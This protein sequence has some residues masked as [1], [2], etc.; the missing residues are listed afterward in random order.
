MENK[1][2]KNN[3]IPGCDQLTR[4]EE[5]QELSKYLGD[6]KT[7]Q[8]RK[9]KAYM[10]GLD[11]LFVPGH[12]TGLFPEVTLEDHI[13]ALDLG[14]EEEANTVLEKK[15]LE[16]KDRTTPSLGDKI[17]GLS[18]TESSE[19]DER[20]INIPVYNEVTNLP[21]SPVA[22]LVEDKSK[23]EDKLLKIV[24]DNESELET[25]V[26]G[27]G[28]IKPV[29]S[30]EDT[31]IK[32]DTSSATIQDLDSRVVGLNINSKDELGDK[33]IKIHPE[34]DLGLGDKTLPLYD[35]EDP[36]LSN[37][38]LPLY[39]SR[40]G[41]L[42]DKVVKTYDPKEDK[43]ED[44][45]LQINPLEIENLDDRIVALKDGGNAFLED[46]KI[47]LS[48][49]TTPEIALEDK[50]LE[51]SLEGEALEYYKKFS[52]FYFGNTL[53][54]NGNDI[55]EKYI[56]TNLFNLA[57]SLYKTIQERD[58]ARADYWSKVL[59]AL[60]KYGVQKLHDLK[61]VRLV[62]KKV[63]L[64]KQEQVLPSLDKI[65]PLPPCYNEGHEACNPIIADKLA[66]PVPEPRFSRD[67]FDPFESYLSNIVSLAE[68]ENWKDSVT[69]GVTSALKFAKNKM[70][71]G[72]L[73]DKM[74][75]I[76]IDT[77]NKLDKNSPGTTSRTSKNNRNRLRWSLPGANKEFK[78]KKEDD[79]A[80]RI[81]FGTDPLGN[82]INFSEE[83]VAGFISDY[84]WKE[85]P[86]L[87]EGNKAFDKKEFAKV[88]HLI[89]EVKSVSSK[90]EIKDPVKN[91][92]YKIK[93]KVWRYQKG[94][95]DI[96]D[97]YKES[98]KS[99]GKRVGEDFKKDPFTV[100]KNLSD[101]LIKGTTS[102]SNGGPGSNYS[103][104][105]NRPLKGKKTTTFDFPED[106]GDSMDGIRIR[107]SL[108]SNTNLTSWSGPSIIDRAK[109]S[110][111]GKPVNEYIVYD[112][113]HKINYKSKNFKDR[114]LS[115]YGIQTT[116]SELCNR[117]EIPNS[118]EDLI[119]ILKN[120]EHITNVGRF[121]T[122]ATN[123][124]FAQ[125]LDSN[126]CWEVVI[127]PFVSKKL[128]GGWSYLPAIQEINT[129]N[130]AEHGI[131]TGYNEW[132]PIS[133]FSL[134]KS[135]LLTKQVGLFDGE[136]NVPLAAELSNELTITIVD[137]Q[138]KSWRNYFQKC[139]DVSVYSSQPHDENYYKTGYN[140]VSESDFT[141]DFK[142]G[143][144]DSNELATVKEASRNTISNSLTGKNLNKY[145]GQWIPT[146]VDKTV[147]CA[148]LY[149][150][151]A[152]RIKIFV[153]TQQYSTIR[154]FD[155]LAVL[156]DFSE[157]FNGD[158]DSSPSD[159]NLNFSI[160]GED[161]DNYHEEDI[162]LAAYDWWRKQDDYIEQEKI[163]LRLVKEG[164]AEEMKLRMKAL[165][166]AEEKK[167]EK[168]KEE[169]Q[170]IAA[171]K[172]AWNNREVTTLM[173]Q[174][175]DDKSYANNIKTSTQL[176]ILEKGANVDEWFKNNPDY[177]LAEG[178]HLTVLTGSEDVV[179]SSLNMSYTE[180]LKNQKKFEEYRNKVINSEAAQTLRA[181]EDALEYEE[182][183]R[184]KVLAEIEKEKN[185]Y[186]ELASNYV[187]TA[188]EY[189]KG[190]SFSDHFSD[191]EKLDGVNGMVLRGE[192]AYKDSMTQEERESVLV[193]LGKAQELENAAYN[194]Q[195]TTSDGKIVVGDMAVAWA[196]SRYDNL[197]IGANL[198]NADNQILS[199][200]EQAKK[201]R[202]EAK[203]A[204]SQA[205]FS[206]SRK[207]K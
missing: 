141:G 178:G 131:N 12:N 123:D 170:R 13:S 160:V 112:D 106:S 203:A 40:E 75:T 135:K 21:E 29:N 166:E 95:Q 69:K 186:I 129:L 206:K 149:K 63:N 163:A 36:N 25:K 56:F 121:G 51:L 157:D 139:M 194:T 87:E 167:I 42:E 128:N 175:K 19:L 7:R 55:S 192:G 110:L 180:A 99:Y 122:A 204:V 155:L 196:K 96:L 84:T 26:L 98:F 111:S 197:T 62:D 118:V 15:V 207:N 34:R 24:D 93:K 195:N 28:E 134:Q 126:A 35:T 174:K 70:S 179:N 9:E 31:L 137:D 46:R 152:F 100:V 5:I 79:L 114:Y 173:V 120:S 102:G 181:N 72:G 133:S 119:T 30:L 185:R 101:S 14:K 205:K 85:C 1:I 198:T 74:V 20:I 61:N 124:R 168:G 39:D 107:K 10:S 162:N 33:V 97:K 161:P 158:T 136:F 183:K 68:A 199:N 81:L 142:T 37:K 83:L 47:M 44:K 109:S 187:K 154:K 147:E 49:T 92:Y 82:A 27:P 6:L 3:K 73:L 169:R 188:D 176:I 177:E 94:S 11:T 18:T 143:K 159:L 90:E 151:V 38:T 138:Y 108:S 200:L 132:I 165:K 2:S 76:G 50:E 191:K 58:Q 115:S 140:S 67:Y 48:T 117:S 78:K 16:L 54:R 125:T 113:K 127:T 190:T 148:A 80:E 202:E 193:K 172:A 8:D 66:Y 88:K 146:A 201:L 65:T 57:M 45:V 105:Y 59:T 171:Q 60:S 130:Q 189:N 144:L 116:L 89:K 43:L 32:T 104:V 91:G 103:R 86:T 53:D 164:S 64:G 153:M 71:P 182:E 184:Q 17:I 145:N 4:P 22:L 41:S 77:L 150:N 156:R 52:S 23:L